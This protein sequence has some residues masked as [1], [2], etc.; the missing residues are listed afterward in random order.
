MAKHRALIVIYNGIGTT[1]AARLWGRVLEDKG[2]GAVA[3]GESKLRKLQRS[4][5]E[6][7]SDEI[8]HA[9]L[10]VRVLG[11]AYP[12]RADDEGL[13]ELELRGPLPPGSHPVDAAMSDRP[14]RVERGQ[15]LVW[16]ARPG[17]AVVSDIDDTVLQTGVGNKV[18]MMKRVLFSN[19]LDLKTFEGAPELYRCWRRRGYPLIFVSGSPVNLYSRLTQFLTVHGFPEAALLLK[20]LGAG[21]GADALTEQQEYKLRRVRQVQ[22][23]LPGYR[24]L[25]VGDSGEKDPEVYAE[26]R[27]ADEKGVAGIFIHRVTA[28]RPDSPRLRGELLFNDYPS[29]AREL[30]KRR[31]LTAAE[32]K[33]V[34]GATAAPAA[35][36]SSGASR[37]PGQKP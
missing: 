33:Q 10:S 36:P 34:V 1:A 4:W 16:P 17:V 23:L 25:L 7:E 37:S 32:V 22:A 27:R 3:A 29:L 12:V 11:R 31:A 8:E 28:D 13:F 2:P 21:K 19:A 15:L 5:H 24:L 30:G 9:Q 35:A 14:F 26:V 6:L 20:N 18:R